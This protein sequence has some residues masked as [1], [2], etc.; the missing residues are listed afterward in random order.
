MMSGGRTLRPAHANVKKRYEMTVPNFCKK[1]QKVP[2]SDTQTQARKAF[3][4]THKKC[5]A[6]FMKTYNGIWRNLIFSRQRNKDFRM[7]TASMFE[8][9]QLSCFSYSN[10]KVDEHVKRRTWRYDSRHM[11]LNQCYHRA[12]SG[13]AAWLRGEYKRVTGKPFML[14]LAIGGR[15]G[16]KY[17]TIAALI[18]AL[19]NRTNQVRP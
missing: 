6:A 19:I 12:L 16:R 13:D 14:P 11:A 17:G 7:V 1:P 3:Q 2:R 18:K 5:G 15:V 8:Y 4:T 9:L 10:K